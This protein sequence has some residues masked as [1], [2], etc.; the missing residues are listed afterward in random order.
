MELLMD[1]NME[2]VMVRG[3]GSERMDFGLEVWNGVLKM[4]EIESDSIGVLVKVELEV[5]GRNEG[6]E[7]V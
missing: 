5:V 2:F 6:R 4:K 7:M 1:V 3:K